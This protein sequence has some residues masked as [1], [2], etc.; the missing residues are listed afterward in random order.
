MFVHEE[1]RVCKLKIKCKKN[2]YQKYSSKQLATL[3]NLSGMINWEACIF[4]ST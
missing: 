1:K 2:T 4:T 3:I